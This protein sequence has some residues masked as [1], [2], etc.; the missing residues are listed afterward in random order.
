MQPYARVTLSTRSPLF[1]LFLLSSLLTTHALA[2]DSAPAS[3]GESCL[4]ANIV[5]TPSR[6]TVTNATDPTQCGVLEAEYGFESQWPGSDS[7]RDDFTGGLR[8]GLTPNLDLHYA[9]GDYL[10]ISSSHSPLQGGFGDVW[11]G[12]KYRFLKQTVLRPSLGVFYQAK[13]PTGDASLGLGS[14]QVDHLTAILV[15]KDVRKF[16]FDFNVIPMFIGRTVGGGFDHNVG[17]AWSGTY[18]ISKKFSFVAEPYGYTAL[19][20]SIPGYTSL[21]AGVTYQASRRMFLDTGMDFGVMHGAPQ[22]RV[23]LGVTY[24]VANV[25]RWFRPQQ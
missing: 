14:G 11:L 9:S 6:P 13:V 7:R 5:S 23:Y 20:S 1:T 19:N 3:E 25:Y 22:R 18:P 2:Q 24:A 17:F 8:L 10:G 12:L 4:S 16:H 21:M 15:S